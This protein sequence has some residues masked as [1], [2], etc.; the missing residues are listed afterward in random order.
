MIMIMIIIILNAG[1]QDERRRSNKQNY[2]SRSQGCPL[3]VPTEGLV[4]TN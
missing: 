4:G 3:L 2:K 1:V